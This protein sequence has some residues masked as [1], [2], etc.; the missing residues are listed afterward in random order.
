MHVGS[1]Q[2]SIEGFSPLKIANKHVLQYGE[3]TKGDRKPA[4]YGVDERD[5][6]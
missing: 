1:S 5:H 4:G 6:G 2:D 3:S